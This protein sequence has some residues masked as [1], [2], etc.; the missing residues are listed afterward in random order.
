MLNLFSIALYLIRLLPDV[1]QI[2]VDFLEFETKNKTNGICDEN[3]QL[4]I[5]SPFA[6]AYI[7]VKK[8]CGSIKKEEVGA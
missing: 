8:F 7:P 2:R 3:N 5:T 1:C 4:E 6:R